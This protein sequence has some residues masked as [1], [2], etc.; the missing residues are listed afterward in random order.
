[1]NIPILL[2]VGMKNNINRLEC[3]FLRLF[4]SLLN[5]LFCK[6]KKWLWRRRGRRKKKRKQKRSYCQ[7]T[8]LSAFPDVTCSCLHSP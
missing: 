3:H 2:M 1:M 7:S 4:L 5:L 6:E 8:A